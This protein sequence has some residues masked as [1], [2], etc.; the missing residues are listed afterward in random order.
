M[1]TMG[2]S[3]LLDEPTKNRLEKTQ[4]LQTKITKFSQTLTIIPHL[5]HFI[6]LFRAEGL[7]SETFGPITAI[8]T[9]FI[10]LTAIKYVVVALKKAD[11]KDI[12]K[13][14]FLVFCLV[15]IGGMIVGIMKV[16]K[17]THSNLI[18][19]FI[20]HKWHIINALCCIFIHFM[21]MFLKF[22]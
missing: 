2:E 12:L 4:K 19:S 14:V 20:L 5:I 16:Y 9:Q 13:G 22:K 3:P 8:L 11:Y 6:M 1:T 10:L 18:E 7:T 17:L 15:Q 21:T